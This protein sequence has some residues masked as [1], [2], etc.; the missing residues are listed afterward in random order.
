LN[1]HNV[2]GH[3]PQNGQIDIYWLGGAGF[4]I[5]F[6]NGLRVC[7]DPYLSDSVN[8]LVGF[9]RLIPIP[10]SPG[11]LNCD[12]LLISHEHGDHLD[13]DSFD[14]IRDANPSMKVLAPKSCHE[15]LSEHFAGYMC[16]AP[17]ERI[18]ERGLT[19]QPVKS[20]HGDLSPDS[21]GFV[22]TY[23]GRSIYLVGDTALN[24]DLLK[25]AITTMPEITIPCINGAFGNMNEEESARL[26]RMCN[27][28]IAI[29]TH[30]GLLNEHGGDVQ[31]F[32]DNMKTIAPQTHVII[33]QPGEGTT[34]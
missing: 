31:K 8:R 13:I 4:L 19:I 25:P 18:E 26:V 9:K 7:I 20:D 22:L 12:V 21:L 28:K 32:A 11:K 24:I 23:K 2:A 16:V 15:F 34:I 1:I 14:D 30:Y 6:D 27:S 33:L 17:G 10:I 29:P 3:L 5:K